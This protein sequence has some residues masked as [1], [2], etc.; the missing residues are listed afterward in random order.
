MVERLV[1]LRAVRYA[2]ILVQLSLALCLIRFRYAGRRSSTTNTFK[3][4]QLG[5][6]LI[7]S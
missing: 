2:D 7:K 6:V 3:F 5:K 1:L 4:F